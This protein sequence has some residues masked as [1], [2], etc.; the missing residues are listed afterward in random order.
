MARAVQGIGNLPLKC[1]QNDSE[2]G[3]LKRGCPLKYL[4]QW[5]LTGDRQQLAFR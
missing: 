3:V 4:R 5:D 2:V 1:L